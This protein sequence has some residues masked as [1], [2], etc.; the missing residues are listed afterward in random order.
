M[1]KLVNI[2]ELCKILN[3]IDT[4]TNKPQNHIIRYWEKEFS[5]IKPKKINRRRYYGAKDIQLIKLI[6]SLTR[7][8]KITIAGVKNILNANIKKL[9]EYDYNSL[10]DY[11]KSLFKDKSKKILN[12]V[13]K[14][15]KY[16][17]KV[18]S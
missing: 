4:K 5:Q 3:L 16:G 8:R 7:D 14:L 12:K 2:S 15:K 10:N 9:D 17:K 13:S 1:H 11:Y 18:T 6:K